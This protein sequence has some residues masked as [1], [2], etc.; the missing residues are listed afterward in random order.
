[1]GLEPGSTDPV[2][3]PAPLDREPAHDGGLRHRPARRLSVVRGA[4]RLGEGS[5]A[6]T[7]GGSLN[8]STFWVSEKTWEESNQDTDSLEDMRCLTMREM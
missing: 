4:G 1:M 6:A 2:A 7:H 3:V 5:G 8:R